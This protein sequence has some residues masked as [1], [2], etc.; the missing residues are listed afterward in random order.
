MTTGYILDCYY[1]NDLPDLALAAKS[2]LIGVIHK[3]SEG[4]TF[5]DPAYAGR[6]TTV[7]G[8]G[9]LWGAYHFG[10]AGDPIAQADRFLAL[11]KP[12]DNTLLCLDLE[13]ALDGTFMSLAEAGQFVARIWQVTNRWPVVYTAKWVMDE[14]NPG[15]ATTALSNCPLWVASYANAPVVPSPW[16]GWNLWQFTNGVSG[17]LPHSINGLGHNDLNSFNG[18][19]DEL[20]SFWKSHSEVTI[21]DTGA[22]L[23]RVSTAAP[24]DILDVTVA[25]DRERYLIP[26]ASVVIKAASV[27]PPPT[28]PPQP[29]PTAQLVANA[30]NVNVRDKAGLSGTVLRRLMAGDAV[31]IDGQTALADNLIWDHILPDA[32]VAQKYLSPAAAP[33][34]ASSVFG[35]HLLIRYNASIIQQILEAGVKAGKPIRCV[36][37]FEAGGQGASVRWIK[38]IS[39]KTKVV[40]RH[41]ESEQFPIDWS[42]EKGDYKIGFDHATALCAAIKADPDASAADWHQ[43]LVNE[44]PPGVATDEFWNGVLDAFDAAGLKAAIFDFGVGI[45]DL[46]WWT[47]PEWLAVL[48]RAKAKGHV[49]LLH[50]YVNP[51]D[52]GDWTEAGSEWY[53]LRHRQIYALLPA[54]ARP[55]LICGEY[56]DEKGAQKPDDWLLHN[57]HL[58]ET[59]VRDEPY[60]ISLNLWSFG[61]NG[62]NNWTTDDLTVHAAAF[63]AYI[64]GRA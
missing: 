29:R 11:A 46:S 25:N 4:L 45:P 43:A 50:E 53:A 17:P 35:F 47:R 51:G 57:L 63:E 30:D 13:R 42:D 16:K 54:D 2:G 40:R 1:N 62:V 37:D 12:G 28:P 38:G 10:R 32:W 3:C 18:T 15:G 21:R 7:E 52:H 31:T 60:L 56:G 36:T 26:V 64:Q 59:A 14:I 22:F 23:A 19:P 24:T 34:L 39:P 27:E 55:F 44:P 5:V 33:I 9:L 41:W 58:V 48:R 49:L 61:D 20:A 8:L 6:R